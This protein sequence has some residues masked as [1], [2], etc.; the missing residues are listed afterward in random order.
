MKYQIKVPGDW[1]EDD[2][3]SD[4]NVHIVQLLIE[5]WPDRPIPAAAFFQLVEHREFLISIGW[6]VEVES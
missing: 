1:I 5:N 6:L 4:A 3:L 2:R